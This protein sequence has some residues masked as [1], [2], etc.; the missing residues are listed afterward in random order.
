M[1]FHDKKMAFCVLYRPE[2]IRLAEYFEKI[3]A[4]LYFLNLL[5]QKILIFG[6]FNIDTLK[7]EAVQRDYKFLLCAYNVAITNFEPTR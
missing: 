5:N 1:L 3:E 6:D 7:D 2:T 4:Q